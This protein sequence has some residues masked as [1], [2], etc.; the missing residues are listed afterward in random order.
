MTLRNVSTAL[1]RELSAEQADERDRDA[2]VVSDAAL[3][4]YEAK[5]R[6]K[7]G[8][9]QRAHPARWRVFGLSD[10]EVIDSLTLRLI[11]VVRS[12]PGEFERYR[13]SGKEWGLS[14]AEEQ[15]QR[16]K[17]VFRLNAVPADFNEEPVPERAANQ[18]EQWLELEAQRTRTLAQECAER[19][20][21]RP[22]R[23]WLAALKLSANAGAFFE[24]S[25]LPNLSAAS[26]VLG[27][28]R[29]SAL[30]A[31]RELRGRFREELDRLE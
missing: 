29:S 6:R 10:E 28:D 4:A 16:L 1:E 25:D 13:R 27:K 12:E 14:C 11:E 9:L 7:L 21:N 19:G 18:E 5:W 26:R 2:A 3:V 30:R 24:S 23:A 20:L 31:Y 17:K 22:Q 8:R 15:L